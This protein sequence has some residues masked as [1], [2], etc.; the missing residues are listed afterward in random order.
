[1]N[2][3]NKVTLKGL[4]KNKTR[5]IVTIIGVIL[6]VAMITAVTT[7]ISSMQNYMV[8]L[9]IA[10]EGDWHA[11]VHNRN[12]EDIKTLNNRDDIEEVGLTKSVGYS[13]LEGSVNEYKPYLYI[14]EFDQKSFDTLPVRLTSGRLPRNENEIIISDHTSTN[15]GVRHRIGDT[16]NLVIGQRIS[17]DGTVLEQKDSYIH[18][19]TG[20]SEKLEIT[21]TRTF[22]VVGICHRLSHTLEDFSAPGYTAITMLN[23]DTLTDANNLSIYFKAKNP[24]Q[25]YNIVGN[26]KN[27]EN[28]Q[29]RCNDDLLRYMGISNDSSFNSVLY[30]LGAI[31]IA[32]IMVGSIS[33]IYNSFAISVS[34]RK[35]Q[36][37]LLSGAGA[38]SKQLKHSVLF[39]ALVIAGIGIPLGVLSGILGIDITLYFIDDLFASMISSDLPVSLT[40]SV[41]IYSVIIA[42]LVAL[43][44]ILISAYIPA[45]R[46]AKMSAI[47]AIRQTEDIKLTQKQVKTSR[48]TRKLFGIE[49]DFALKNLKRN[50]R[51]YRSTVISLFISIVLFVSASAFSMYLKDSVTNVYEDEK[52][53]LAYFTNQRGDL[54]DSMKN[55]Y[56]DILALDSVD[57]G[58]VIKTFYSQTELPREKVEESFYRD[59]VDQ[60]IISEGEN[61]FVQIE[62]YGVDHDTFTEYIQKLGIDKSR[63]TDANSPAGIAVDKQHYYD[64]QSKKYRNTNIFKQHNPQ[65]IQI[66]Y[67]QEEQSAKIDISIA[68]FADT[69]PFG[70]KDYTQD[71]SI[72]LIVD[73]SLWETI[74]ADTSEYMNPAYMC[75]KAEDPF[76]AEEDMKNILSESGLTTSNIFNV[77]EMLQSNR[78]IIIII[79][80]FSYGFII[81]ISLITIA[82]VFNTISTN[83][84]LRRREFAMLKSVGMTDKSFNKMLNYECIF[85]GLKALL[86][87]LPVSV[88]VTYLIHQKI[89]EGVDMMFYLPVQGILVSVF[90]VFLVVFISMMYSMSKIRKENILDALKNENL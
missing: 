2:I 49:G 75:F 17:E 43:A 30:G 88:L 22:T 54:S 5:T 45:R 70:I 80:V 59:K 42:I 36:F 68:A 64:F 18:E 10:E 19:E 29:Y 77:A 81:L 67:S 21:G 90:S 46:S 52:Y 56:K 72:M 37:G 74:F 48:L 28:D 71:D 78:N 82:N 1:M 35:K 3:I 11:V 27:I 57:E 85:Y 6:S 34:E 66:D 53:D 60:E 25:I 79:S 14:V 40:L 44:T 7:L 4:K 13:M 33:L 61:A 24:G 26:L 65:I 38:T 55:A 83:V 41:S 69:A 73:D 89:N 87:G 58:A 8:N 20:A 16:L 23:E 76:K 84:N 32:L 47:D 51:R 12:Y 63:F 50:R 62:V 31:L 9:T 86:F 15:G 39:E